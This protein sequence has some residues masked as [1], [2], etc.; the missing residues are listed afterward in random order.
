MDG[1]ELAAA[2]GAH[3]DA[4]A[5]AD[6]TTDEVTALLIDAVVAWG[7]ARGWRVYRRAASVVPLPPPYERQHSVV[8]VG[9]ARADGPPVVVEVDHGDRRRTA[10]KLRA[11]AAAGRV[12]VWVRWGGGRFAPVEPPVHAVVCRV[13]SRTALGSGVR[14]HSRAVDSDRPAPEHTS[15]SGGYTP[16][17]LPATDPDG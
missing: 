7:L 2:L 15:A 5:F 12:A 16:E 3:L 11:E 8:D 1:D 10:E 14:V 9:C 17:A 6:R 4:L 13:T